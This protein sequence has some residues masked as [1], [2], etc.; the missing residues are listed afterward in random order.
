MQTPQANLNRPSNAFSKRIVLYVY[1]LSMATASV[2]EKLIGFARIP[3]VPWPVCHV[4]GPRWPDIPP[5]SES[6]VQWQGRIN[7]QNHTSPTW[8]L[9]FRTGGRKPP[10]HNPWLCPGGLRPPVLKFS[11]QNPL[12][13]NRKRYRT[14]CS[15]S[16]GGYVQWFHPAL[17]LTE[18]FWP[19]G[20]MS[21]VV[22]VRQSGSPDLPASAAIA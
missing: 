14:L 6:P 7:P 13:C 18:G 19:K 21:G 10:G 22:Y 20:V 16:T 8:K 2:H 12:S 15:N 9:N 17:P 5:R 1:G 11:F 3:Q 4:W